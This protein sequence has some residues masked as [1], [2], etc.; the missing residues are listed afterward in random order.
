MKT[1][2]SMALAK[3]VGKKLWNNKMTVGANA[4]FAY[5][6]F[7][8]AREE[9]EGMVSSLG[10][11]AAGYALPAVMGTG[12]FIGLQLASAL[13]EMAM[14]GADAIGTYSRGLSKTMKH[15]MP[16]TNATFIDSKEAYTM[17]QMGMQLAANSKYNLQ[18]A[19]MGNE[20]RNMHR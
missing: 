4:G 19:L 12:H 10:S 3:A 9:G 2:A 8:T 6:D 5:M 13:P 15:N 17:R 20:A 1:V 16:F 11:A 18:Q 14:A 7:N